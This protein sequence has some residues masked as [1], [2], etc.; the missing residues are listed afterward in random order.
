VKFL[1]KKNTELSLEV[2]PLIDIVFLLLI[3]FVLNSQF[4]KLTSMD[5]SLPKVN[6]NQLNEMVGDNLIIEITSAEQIILNGTLLQEFS[7]SALDDFINKNHSNNKIAVISADSNTKYQYLVTVMDVLN[8][9][10]FERV[11]INAT[12]LK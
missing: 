3:F 12:E 6:S 7:Y 11:E 2:T 10:N 8:K 5:L 9:N 4:D 1:R